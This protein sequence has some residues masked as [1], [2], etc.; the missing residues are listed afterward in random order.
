MASINKLSIRGVRSFSPE[1]AEQVICQFQDERITISSLVLAH[2]VCVSVSCTGGRVLLSLYYNRWGQWL[3]QVSSRLGRSSLDSFVATSIADSR[4]SMLYPVVF[5]TTIIE[6]LKYAVTGAFPPGNKSGQAFVHDPRS[7]GQNQV[8]ANVKLRFT[9]RSGQSMV[10]VRTMEVSQKKSTLTFKQLDGVLR[11]MDE[12]T[13]QRVSL[14]HKCSELDKQ[15]PSLLGVSRAILEHVVF[16]HQDD[17]SWPLQEGAVLKKRF[18]DIFDSTRYTKA[19]EVFRKTEKEFNAK[20]KELKVELASLSSHQF[21][22]GSFRK[23]LTEHNEQIE[24]LDDEKKVIAEAIAETVAEIDTYVEIIGRIDDIDSEIELRKN[25]IATKMQIMNKQR[26]MLDEDLTRQCSVKELQ[27]MLRDFDE[28]M[29]SQFERKQEL[30]SECQRMQ[31]EIESLR[32]EEMR[33]TSQMG[34]L[35]AEKEAHEIRLRDRYTL[36]ENIAQ[37]YSVDLQVSLTQGVNTSF[38]GSM[39]AGTASQT[40]GGGTQD[41]LV[42]ITSDDMQGFFQ[43]LDQRDTELDANLKEH[44]ERTQ[45][46]ED[47]LQSILTEL[48]G[49]LRSIESGK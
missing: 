25:E 6:S 29:K 44:I 41:T 5:R 42:S 48:G 18:D 7:I 22:A 4:C 37:T 45:T 49:R 16:C 26:A 15:L 43:A 47:K 33:L 24:V 12:E 11:M 35:A 23:E 31:Q 39:T 13:G 36:M 27:E 3:W 14:S 19:L 40:M 1:D 9:S 8:K 21:A 10:V 32:R 2:H 38:A 46:Q 28:K 20:A 34:K 17:S 30:E